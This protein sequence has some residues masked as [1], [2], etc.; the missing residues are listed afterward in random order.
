MKSTPSK[1]KYISSK[2]VFVYMLFL[3]LLIFTLV[4]EWW[5]S[6]VPLAN[7][8]LNLTLPYR[9]LFAESI[10]KGVF[11]FWDPYS[12]GGT[13]IMSVYTSSFVNPLVVLL[14]VAPWS[15]VTSLILEI[16]I[17]SIVGFIGMW[18]WLGPSASPLSKGLAAITWVNSAFMIFQFHLNIE[19][20]VSTVFFPWL[21]VGLTMRQPSLAVKVAT[22]GWASLGILTSGYL[23]LIPFVGYSMLFFFTS[24]VVVSVLGRRSSF[25]TLRTIYDLKLRVLTGL[26]I[27]GTTALLLALTLSI[28]L[29]ETLANLDKSV[30]L[31]RTIDPFVASL[32]WESIATLFSSDGLDSFVSR[33]DGGHTGSLYLPT[34]LLLGVG[35][36][37]VAPTRRYASSLVTA[38]LIFLISLSS[39]TALARWSVENLPALNDVRFHSFSLGLILFFLITAAV[40]GTEAL[41]RYKKSRI[42]ACLLILAA[43]LVTNYLRPELISSQQVVLSVA[44][45]LIVIIGSQTKVRQRNVMTKFLLSVSLIVLTSV[46]VHTMPKSMPIPLLDTKS[47]N[48]LKSF[49]ALRKNIRLDLSEVPQR[50]VLQYE[51]FGLFGEMKNHQ[52]LAK[53]PVLLSYTPHAHPVMNRVLENVDWTKEN[54]LFD[55]FY[56]SDDDQPKIDEVIKIELNKMFLVINNPGQLVKLNSTIPWSPN[57]RAVTNQNENLVVEKSHKGF[58]SMLVP[59]GIHQVKLHYQPQFVGV[60]FFMTF[61]GWLMLLFFTLSGCRKS[62]NFQ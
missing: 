4:G 37:I 2:H 25:V 29:A 13:P 53:I 56:L 33:S 26:I 44:I 61:N 43:G 31:D 24:K 9:A 35:A 18:F 12:R 57:W 59:N 58:V 23:G 51:N 21:M 41:V 16:Y 48:R 54:R 36:G 62:K 38:T 8:N 10:G 22:I 11:P 3:H 50:R 49:A 34:L 6:E 28:P 40:E 14:A 47:E 7:D 39:S 46:Q 45:L 30:F 15:V 55:F 42:S 5:S 20:A 17:Y 1:V 27:L 32:H 60:L 52:I 19:V